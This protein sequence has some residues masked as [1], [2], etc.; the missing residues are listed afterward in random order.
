MLLHT[1]LWVYV[2]LAALRCPSVVVS[3]QGAEGDTDS[4]MSASPTP[5]A[6]TFTIGSPISINSSHL[7][8]NASYSL[9]DVAAPLNYSILSSR[10]KAAHVRAQQYL[11][12]WTIEEKVQL[13]TGMGWTQG[14]CVG[15]TPP[16][17]AHNWTGLCLEDSPLGVRYT[18][19]VSAWPAGINAA[20]T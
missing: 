18:D 1:L 9:I 15:N 10:W 5:S 6:I 17:P 3:A 16:I 19:G 20:A 8:S 7:D 13:C 2:F 11:A 14:R 12:N 4:S